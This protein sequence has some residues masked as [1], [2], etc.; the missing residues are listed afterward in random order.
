LSELMGYS[1]SL[2]TV[3]SGMA[4][5]SMHFSHYNKVNN[6]IDEARI[7]QEVRGF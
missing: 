7:L 4:T 2:R 5:F 1:T 6:A 3:S